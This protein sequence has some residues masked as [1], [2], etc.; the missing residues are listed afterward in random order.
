MRKFIDIPRKPRTLAQMRQYLA[1]HYRYQDRDGG[2]GHNVRIRNL[3]LTS[4]EYDACFDALYASE[5][6]A[7]MIYFESGVV[8]KLRE[9]DKTHPGYQAGQAGRSAGYI[10]LHYNG[11]FSH[12]PVW[13]E[14]EDIEDSY[15]LRQLFSSVWDFD[16]A[17]NAAIAAFVDY[18][19]SREWD[20]DSDDEPELEAEPN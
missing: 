11:E 9:F 12:G 15:S 14:P 3:A 7:G 10:C 13:A 16:Q 5:T 8:R 18:A 6:G 1:D 4:A 17:A 20:T 19:V 2:I